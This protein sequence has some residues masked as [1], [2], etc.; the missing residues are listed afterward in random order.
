MKP[1]WPLYGLCAALAIVV[2][3]AS[4]FLGWSDRTAST[5]AGGGLAVLLWIYLPRMDRGGQRGSRAR[6]ART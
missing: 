5:V 2:V 3:A 1:E 6:S 4:E